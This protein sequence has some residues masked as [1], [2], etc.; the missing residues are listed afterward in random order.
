MH[1]HI[2]SHSSL[3]P[4]DSTGLTLFM[5]LPLQW[6]MQFLLFENVLKFINVCIFTKFKQQTGFR[7]CH[8]I[9]ESFDITLHFKSGHFVFISINSKPKEQVKLELD[10]QIKI[11]KRLFIHLNTSVKQEI[12]YRT[13]F[14]SKYFV[15]QSIFI[16]ERVILINNSRNSKQEKT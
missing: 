15:P 4:F 7:G 13:K 5:H 2:S 12:D 9:S 16:I 1:L 11:A 8:V 6:L 10:S 14:F 3:E